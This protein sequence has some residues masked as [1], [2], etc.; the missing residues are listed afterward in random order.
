M[1]FLTPK[2]RKRIEDMMVSLYEQKSTFIKSCNCDSISQYLFRDNEQP[3]FYKFLHPL[4][5]RIEEFENF[6]SEK[7]RDIEE[8]I[9]NI[10]IENN[11][12]FY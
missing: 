11:V 7:R 4:G 5:I 6:S 1:L 9:R 2:Q 8:E 10:I 12:Y 3:W